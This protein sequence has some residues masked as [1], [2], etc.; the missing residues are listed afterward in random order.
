MKKALIEKVKLAPH[1]GRNLPGVLR[2]V[3]GPLNP[4]T[5]KPITR[6]TAFPGAPGFEWRDCADDVAP[7]THEWN[8]TT[9]VRK[10]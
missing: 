3:V 7:E 2:A 10:A 6:D 4:D 1:D 5:G 9:F 8:G